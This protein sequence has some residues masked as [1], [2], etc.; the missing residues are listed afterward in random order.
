MKN[1]SFLLTWTPRIDA[2]HATLAFDYQ[3]ENRG[4][5][6]VWVLDEL[7]VFQGNGFGV[8]PEATVTLEDA[9]QAGRVRLIRGYV[10]PVVTLPFI[11]LRPTA[12]RL[13]AGATV[14]GRGHTAWPLRN[15]HPNDGEWPLRVPAREAVLEVGVLPAQY[16]LDQLPLAGEG[17][18]PVPRH[19]DAFQSQAFISSAPLVLP[20]AP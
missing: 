19:A 16:A 17:V 8:D 9:T 11:E 18:A 14:N 12:R 2:A 3:L 15:W 7:M 4:P 10:P 1:S 6:D 5:D 20:T 13:A